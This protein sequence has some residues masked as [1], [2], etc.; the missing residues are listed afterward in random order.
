MKFF[1]DMNMIKY[2]IILLRLVEGKNYFGKLIKSNW[3]R[4]NL[5]HKRLF[6]SDFVFLT[7]FFFTR[8]GFINWV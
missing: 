2:W 3:N 8:Y 5:I 1:K 7:T 4:I 6:N